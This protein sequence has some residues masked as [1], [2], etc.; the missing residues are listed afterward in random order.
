MTLKK[1]LFLFFVLFAFP[2]V[3]EAQYEQMRV[4]RIDIVPE[5]LPDETPFNPA[6]V[7]TRMRTKIGSYFSQNEFDNDLKSLAQEYDRIEPRIEVINNEIQITLQIWLKP[8]IRCIE[9][10]GNERYSSKKLNK[11]LELNANEVFEREKFIRAFNKLKQLYVKKGYF[12]AEL[13]YQI[14]PS[15]EGNQV[16]ILITICE[17]R[18]GKIK[19]IRFEGLTPDEESGVLETIM[20]KKYNLFLSWYTGRGTYH[21]EMIEHDRLLMINHF[22]NLGYADAMVTLNIE[23]VPNADRIILIISVD[24]GQLYTFGDVTFCGNTLYSDE[25]IIDQFDFKP[26]SCFSPEALRA[27]AQALSDLYGGCGY[28]ETSVDIQLRLRENCPVYDVNINISEGEQYYIGLIK[29][30]GNTYTKTSVILHESL[31][32]PGEIFDIRKLKT[33]ENR[34][35]NTG[36][37][38]NVNVYAVR[39]QF[40]CGEEDLQYRD[41][42]IEVAETDTG[43]IGL[44]FG[45]S[46][47]ARLFGG[48][49]LTENNFNIM[50]LTHIFDQGPIALRGG[51][52]FF[53]IKADFGDR[54]TTYGVQWT[55]PYF[56]DTPW[57]LGIDVEKSNNRALSRSYAIKTYGGHVHTTYLWNEYLKYDIFYRARHSS[58]DIRGDEDPVLR[59]E[60][61]STGFISALGF[62]VIFDSTNNPRRPTSGLRSRFIYELAGIGGNFDFMKFAALNSYYFPFSRR[63]TFKFRAD[64]QFILPYGST[65]ADT[66]P[67]S[68]RLFLGGETTVRGYRSFIIG[69]KAAPNEPKGGISSLLISEEYQYNLLMAPCVDAFAFVDAGTVTNQ[70]FTLRHLATSVGFGL[71][72]EVM[73][74]MPIMVGMGWPIHPIEII[75]DVR[76]DNAQRFFFAM[77]GSF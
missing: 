46:S 8:T 74:N 69:P 40:E 51:G 49:E 70:A 17:G 53:H 31:L 76:Y 65:T 13:D 38:S 39:S 45:F 75:N 3:A 48:I 43:N 67:L 42:Y 19:S 14:T 52:E 57:I 9:F 73:R 44:F 37:F 27:T 1:C 64:L 24:K 71:R 47:L 35:C 60:I 50:G 62:S 12:E 33:T 5:N 63:G 58:I 55:K 68:E 77:G 11:T 15:K 25:E 10:S 29:V 2:F 16:D 21:P 26:G 28:I 32:C 72:I 4:V 22:Q 36:F 66:L 6:N 20:T 61:E 54:Q 56:L 41:V 18:A 34:L 7:R 59:K 23:E 30:F